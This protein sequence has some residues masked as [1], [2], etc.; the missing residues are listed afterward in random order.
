[1]S[2]RTFSDRISVFAAVICACF[3]M[4]TT[5]QADDAAAKKAATPK[6]APA[7]RPTM[8]DNPTVNSGRGEPSLDGMHT[9]AAW[10]Y[11]DRHE[12][13]F[14]EENGR[15]QI[16]WVIYEPATRNPTFR[17]DAVAEL[18]GQPDEFRCVFSTFESFDGTSVLYT[19]QSKKGK[20]SFK[21]GTEYS[22]LEP[23]SGFEVMD[24]KTEKKVERIPLLSPGVYRIVASVKNSS[25]KKEALA[26]S[27]FTVG[28]E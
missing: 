12:G 27:H 3:V 6:A 7:K 20:G 15:P 24:R 28:S 17:V 5:G 21:S 14:V 13:E 8:D 1:M 23:G 11:I 25:T 19:I 26:I 9:P 18:L 22:L 4:A 2:N 10:I 16:Q